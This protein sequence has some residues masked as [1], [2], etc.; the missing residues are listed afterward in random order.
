MLGMH[1]SGT[2][3]TARL[4]GE[5]GCDFGGELLS[6]RVDNPG[7]YFE[8]RAVVEAHNDFL[9][10]V[11]REWDDPRPWQEE[12]GSAA[13]REARRSLEEI[14]ER[15]FSERDLW[16]LKDPRLCRL[17]P[18]WD[19]ILARADVR[20]VVVH[21]HPLAVARSL[22]RRDGM[23]RERALLLWMRH[24][25]EAE[26]STRVWKRAYVRFEELMAD[27]GKT[28]P[29]MMKGLGLSHRFDR[30]S[31]AADQALESSQVHHSVEDA[32]RSLLRRDFPWVHRCHRAF[33]ELDP[34]SSAGSNPAVETSWSELE[35]A[36]RLFHLGAVVPWV[37]RMA[38]CDA[39]RSLLRRAIKEKDRY[40]VSMERGRE[41]REAEQEEYVA[42][43]S[44]TVARLEAQR[45]E[46]ESY[47]VSLREALA[48]AEEYSA[49]LQQGLEDT[50]AA[51]GEYVDALKEELAVRDRRERELLER[52]ESLESR[53]QG[54]HPSES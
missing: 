37:E 44:A 3:A 40:V 52:I 45:E 8:H 9:R 25:L 23:Q 1:R 38:E 33:C 10:A 5:L 36:D 18:L 32:D 19:G 26:R 4:L 51:S 13:A 42:S 53:L 21:R 46:Q 50:R 47:V 35:A 6:G 12:F 48:R 54:P 20:F 11:G 29:G 27:P 30:W 14:F 15:D 17:L 43:L 24:V 49:S 7:G 31:G 16:V 39:D 28:I 34:E 22:Q 2:S 41:R